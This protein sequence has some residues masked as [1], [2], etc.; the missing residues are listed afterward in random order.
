M[1][2]NIDS[3]MKTKL[4]LTPLLLLS[5][6][7]S[8]AQTFEEKVG[9][10]SCECLQREKDTSEET[11]KKCVSEAISAVGFS[12]ADKLKLNTVE[13]IQNTYKAI[14]Q[15]LKQNCELSAPDP[16]KEA[17]YERSESE[18]ANKMFDKANNYSSAGDLN[19]AIKYYEKALKKD[20]GFIMALDNLGLTYRRLDK[21]EEAVKYYL[22]SLAVYPEGTFALQ[23]LAVAYSL[24]ND[25]ENS[26]LYYQ[27]LADLYP[28]D[29]EGYFGKARVLLLQEKFDASL[30]QAFKA[31]KLYELQQNPYLEDC[32]KLLAMLYQQFEQDGR[33]ESFKQIA[34]END[35][36]VEVN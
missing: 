35:V 30:H 36:S 7:A 11:I 6:S 34:T 19:N 21:L 26:L 29:P 2:K 9:Q 25:F 12:D 18:A 8:F 15:Y 28:N 23:N 1:G 3:L 10:K 4:I 33:L 16:K 13:S 32:K 31:Y 20:P 17:V 22:R 14:H 5:M 24:Q 27:K